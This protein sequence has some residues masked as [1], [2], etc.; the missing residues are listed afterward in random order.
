MSLTLTL[1]QFLP[2]RISRLAERVSRSLSQ[3]YAQRFSITVPQWRVLATL[4]ERPG[5]TASAVTGLTNL[6]KVK[7]SRAVTELHERGLI[8]RRASAADRR[9]AELTLTGKGTALFARIAP[10]ASDWENRL[11][12]ALSAQE[13]R[14][15]FRLLS[16]LEEHLPLDTLNGS[17]DP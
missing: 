14:E 10:L 1:E 4:A 3:V 6:D 15:L 9:A 16:R 17:E 7:V 13:R 8:G 5:L 2:Y 11:L 12:Q